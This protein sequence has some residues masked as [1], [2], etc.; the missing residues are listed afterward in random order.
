[1]SEEQAAPAGAES[2]TQ[3]AAAAAAYDLK[4]LVA[5]LKARGVDVAED[6]AK[7]AADAVLSWVQK[8]ALASE[9]KFDDLLLP[10]MEVAK[11]HIM[12]QLDKIDG[13]AG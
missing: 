4:E 7:S 5:E 6:L 3:P 1:M 9:N 11:P 8:S 10:L 13:K 12:E 2:S